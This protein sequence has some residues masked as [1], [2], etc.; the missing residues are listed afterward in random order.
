MTFIIQTKFGRIF[1]TDAPKYA[2]QLQRLYA[3]V[4]RAVADRS[5]NFGGDGVQMTFREL[6][7]IVRR[8]SR[9][10]MSLSLIS[11]V[12]LSARLRDQAHV[13]S[14]RQVIESVFDGEPPI[15]DLSEISLRADPSDP[16]RIQFLSRDGAVVGRVSGDLHRMSLLRDDRALPK[17][18]REALFR[19]STALEF[20]EPVLIMGGISCK[21]EVARAWAELCASSD[22]S[23]L[24]MTPETEA[25][26]GMGQIRPFKSIDAACH[27][28]QLY[29]GVQSRLVLISDKA[30]ASTLAGIRDAADLIDT[31]SR[32]LD[33]IRFQLKNSAP[34]SEAESAPGNQI[35]VE[36]SVP[37]FEPAFESSF[38]I[39]DSSFMPTFGDSVDVPEFGSVESD[40]FAD[41]NPLEEE[42]KTSPST[43]EWHFPTTMEP[44]PQPEEPPI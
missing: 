44:V 25:S 34:A 41:L 18:F 11:F 9:T 8:Y 27:L 24:H 30:D 15:P 3:E 17:T 43:E 10:G 7:K 29:K 1:G 31:L 40:P 28:L 32:R 35:A 22:L 2:A 19:V 12:L 20:G 14:L 38:S 42:L 37:I 23:T 21:S 4:N 13:S 6:T 5:I 36:P 39:G 16:A 26:D 33:V